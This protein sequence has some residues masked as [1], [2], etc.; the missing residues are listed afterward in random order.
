MTS[1]CKQN[2]KGI[3]GIDIAQM[4]TTVSAAEDFYQFANGGWIKNNPLPAE[5]ARYGNF[6]RL[7][8]I[9]E[10]QVYTLITEIAETEHPQGS[11]SQK[12][13]DL[14]RLAMDS[15][16]LNTEKAAPIQ[17][18]LKKIEALHSKT[19][20]S[21][22]LA[23]MNKMGVFPF[24]MLYVAADDM[25]SDTT[26]LQTY[27][28]GLG[29]GARDYYLK[30]D[31][32]N[33]ELRLKY[34]EHV[35]KMFQLAGDSPEKAAQ[36]TKDVMSIEMRLAK[37]STSLEDLRN[38]YLN[39]HKMTVDE[40]CETI[41]GLDWKYY[42][43]ACF[44]SLDIK[45]INIGQERFMKETASIFEKTALSVLKNY[46]R[47]NLIN[48]AASLLGD[49]MAQ[50][51]FDFY[52]KTLSGR[53]ELQSRWKRAIQSLNHSLGEAV[54]QIYVE[55]YFPIEAKTRML[56]LVENLRL[57]L[58]ERIQALT[59]MSQ[60]TKEKAL[61][62]LATF[63]V[64]IAYPDK[65]KDY[66][67]I[68][69]DASRSYYENLKQV[70]LFDFREMAAKIDRP[71]DKEE[72]LMNPQTV[73]AY[74]NPSTNEICFPAGILQAPFFDMNA[75][76]AV[77]YG[78]I[79]VIIGHEMT[80]GFDDQGC[81]YDKDGNLAN[82]WTQEDTEKF[83]QRTKIL[84]E[85][86]NKIEVAPGLFANGKF[87][88]GE[89]IADNGG[90]QVSFTAYQKTEE[91]KKLQAI[92]GFTPTQCFFIAY[93][94]VWASNIRPEEILRRTAEDP[95]SLGKWRVNGTL[96]NIDAFVDAFHI[97][98]GDA[99]YIPKEERAYIW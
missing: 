93:A 61:E 69:I 27:Q 37:A 5:Y 53:E 34:L 35:N 45:V 3:S 43:K 56:N 50:Q 84:E 24:F 18:D 4:D 63:H 47:W 48:N 78:A 82:W 88:L 31:A 87:T 13:A 28:A 33:K 36:A 65:W 89:N 38:P 22:H 67:S 41:S 70:A 95:H 25:N 71:V 72:W 14:Y 21:G 80:H 90:L 11:V 98:E 39:Y 83:T 94:R 91:Y 46:F 86:F 85:Q 32:R 77:N 59:W 58:G 62:K 19:E 8:E 44:D 9:T 42:F 15:A 23:E 97:K 92:D 81:Q 30:K 20:L 66:S 99:M 55:K 16:R 51:D 57:G 54:G 12:I 26:I 2:N 74:Y 52:G 96:P 60:E 79:G 7:G 73:N 6:E 49:D 40:L 1:C 68:D 64:K 76:D 75:Y 17:A 10:K 29:M